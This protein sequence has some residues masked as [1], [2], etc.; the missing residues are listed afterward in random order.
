MTLK[1]EEYFD[2]AA[3]SVIGFYTILHSQK[4]NWLMKTIV[5][6]VTWYNTKVWADNW[7][8][9]NKPNESNE[10]MVWIPGGSFQWEPLKMRVYAV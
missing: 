3:I 4:L 1:Q 8:I 6:V 2:R 7:K 5:R 10:G 9:N